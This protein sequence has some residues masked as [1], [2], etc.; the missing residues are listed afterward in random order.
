MLKE[1]ELARR[2]R[3]LPPGG[4]P[5][6]D[7]Q[8][9]LVQNFADQAVIAIENTRLLNE[10][11]ESL[12][13]QTATAD[14]LKVI[15]RSTFDLQT[16]LDTLVEIGG[17]AVRGRDGV[18]SSVEGGCL[19]LGR[20]LR[21]CRRSLREYASEHSACAG[22]RIASRGAL[23]SKA[24]TVHIPDVLADPEYT[25]S[26]MRKRLAAIRTVLGV[27]LL[28]EG[29][30]DRRDLLTRASVRPF[31]DKQIELVDDLRRPGGDRDRERAAAQRAAGTSDLRIAG[32]ADRHRRGAQVISQLAG[33]P[34]A[35]IRH[36]VWHAMRLLAAS[37]LVMLGCCDGRRS[38]CA[39][40][41]ACAER[42]ARRG[43]S[44]LA[45]PPI[46]P[47]ASSPSA[48]AALDTPDGSYRRCR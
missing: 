39:R 8:I 27:P 19:S 3:H 30:S 17:A 40:L 24:E 46:D 25:L 4:R 38:S 1:N 45:R 12:Q 11:R 23:C 26:E 36:I 35:G 16:V 20:E 9:E 34:A 43:L 13:Q 22:T 7:K 21:L 37:K 32:A 42:P 5:F 44:R 29:T 31:T 48:R 6:T 41:S 33:R 47:G 14:V 28:R 2:D 18:P 15:S 10:L